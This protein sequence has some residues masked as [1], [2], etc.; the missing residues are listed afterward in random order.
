MATNKSPFK[1]K[2]FESADGLALYYRDYTPAD[3]GGLP[4]LCLHG[5]TRN[6][7]DF[8]SIASQLAARHRVI[9][10]DFRGRG[11]SDYDPD[12]RHYHPAQYVAD[13][14]KLVDELELGCMALIGTSL[15]GIMSALM[16][17]E[18]PNAIAGV[19]FNDV[20]PRLDPEGIAR[21]VAGVGKLPVVADR[22]GAVAA[23]RQN[24]EHAFPGWDESQWQW[25]A[26]I[27]YRRRA[28]G[29]F[30]LNYDRNI[31]VAAREGVSGLRADP[32]QLFAE[33][34]NKPVLLVHGALSDILT[35][36][37]VDEMRDVKPDLDVVVVPDRGHAPVLDEPEAQ[38]AIL[39]FLQQID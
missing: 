15:G 34:R 31:G 16:H 1:E 7:R 24:Y 20:G 4:V 19:V 6:S 12:W 10:F 14:W 28:D 22:D 9:A 18:R 37:I 27:T 33:L 25:F 2:F 21:V 39:D 11:R 13:V 5:L 29:R 23:T 17:H 26:D 38:N 8:E 32:W 30:D 3:P 36:E 35:N